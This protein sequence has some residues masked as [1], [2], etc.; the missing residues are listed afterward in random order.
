MCRMLFWREA[1][2]ATI[3]PYSAS[4]VLCGEREYSLQYRIYALSYFA[5]KGKSPLLYCL[6]PLQHIGRDTN[7]T[8]LY[9]ACQP[10]LGKG[11]GK[12]F[13]KAPLTSRPWETSRVEGSHEGL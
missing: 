11:K 8:L 2:F 1:Q 7:I 10:T 9:A 4:M 6:F 12:G 3:I 13:G 5:G